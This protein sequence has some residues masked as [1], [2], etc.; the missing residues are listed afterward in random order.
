MF[1]SR[2]E[3]AATMAVGWKRHASGEHLL[4]HASEIAF[5]FEPGPAFIAI[6]SGSAGEQLQR[7]RE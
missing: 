2:V 6:D 5:R 1:V 4:E 3:V 7:R